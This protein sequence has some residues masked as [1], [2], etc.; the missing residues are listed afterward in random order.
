MITPSSPR[1]RRTPLAVARAVDRA[2][3]LARGS[4]LPGRLDLLRLSSKPSTA[5]RPRAAVH[6][7]QDARFAK[8]DLEI[9]EP[10]HVIPVAS[11]LE[12]RR[13]LLGRL[14]LAFGDDHYFADQFVELAQQGDPLL[15]VTVPEQEDARRAAP[16]LRASTVSTPEAITDAG[17]S[18][19]CDG[20]SS[21]GRPRSARAEPR[22]PG[23]APLSTSTSPWCRNSAR[24]IGVPSSQL[25]R[26][27][28]PFSPESGEDID[29][30]ARY[31]I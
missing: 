17:R 20:A 21:E 13:G 7:L 12:G 31:G 9:F 25:A 26:L 2:V 8:K 11:E 27:R 28:P 23:P 10:A 1:Q 18:P 30:P 24:P 15:A 5:A 22:Y 4:R 6:A 14:G 16:I 19:I 3:R 29:P